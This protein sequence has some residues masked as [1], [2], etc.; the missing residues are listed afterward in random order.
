MYHELPT[1]AADLVM[2]CILG[3]L[4]PL[5]YF[6]SSCKMFAC[7]RHRYLFLFLPQIIARFVRKLFVFCV[8][9][10]LFRWQSVYTFQHARHMTFG[11]FVSFSND[12]VSPN[13]Y[14]VLPLLCLKIR[15]TC[16]MLKSQ[17]R[18]WIE[19]FSVGTLRQAPKCMFE[20]SKC[21]ST[22]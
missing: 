10:V 21:L 7:T 4:V 9:F 3:F 5:M 12:G 22:T 14:N 2:T 19:S 17:H 6:W 8:S 15:L 1:L 16:Y 11:R 18:P 20:W 13:T